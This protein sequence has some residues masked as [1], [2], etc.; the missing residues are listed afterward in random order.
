MLAT[1]LVTLAGLAV[2]ARLLAPG[3]FGLLAFALAYITYVTAIGDLGTGTA[4]IYWPSR[5]GD[6]T[7]V[8]FVISVI[9]GWL[10][11]GGTVLL[12]P[13]IAAFFDNPA[14]APVLIAIAWSVPIQALGS[15]HDALCRKSLRFR[16]WLG[17]ELA[18]AGGKTA[19]SIALAIAG[20]GVWSLVWGHLAGHAFRT[21]LLWMIVPW[22]PTLT[23]PWHL[24]RPMF[25]Y[26]RSIV[27]V[28]VLSV[29][30]HHSDL[31]IVARLLG[32]TALGFYQMAAKIPE[33]AITVLVRAVS[34]VLF[35]AL[36]RAHA[37]GADAVATYL[38]TL[39]GVG[40]VTIPAAV[41]LVMMAEPLVWVV[42][43]PT[44][45]PSVP[46]V[47]ALAVVACLRALGTPGGDLLKAS[48]RPG[49]LVVLAA[50]KAVL[51]LPAL[52][53]AAT[54][55]MLGVALA[56]A[57]VT[58]I[59]ATLD[60]VVACALTRTSGRSV[61]ASIGAGVQAGAAVA[62]GLALVDASLPAAAPPIF[63][64]VALGIGFTAYA[65]AVRL[66]SR[67]T[68]DEVILWGRRL[69]AVK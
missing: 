68:Y 18:L 46:I 9:T 39:R 6:A 19:I 36:S 51:L 34:H 29:I 13:T 61:L 58:A 62:A 22:R 5:N 47:Q 48:G 44:W 55:G 17:P 35:P 52:L 23:M 63:V 21:V 40:L 14:G 7:Q 28:N 20:L 37:E 53:M 15:T 24:V 27:A 60:I 31:L 16:A 64:P 33:M 32:V 69:A 66:V 30:V 50:L 10:W 3:D 65:C 42:F 57:G 12:A 59:T 49:A 43:G 26:G 41:V 8:T 54:A 45:M 11:L 4:L 25:G 67:E 2:L 56:M 1:R 38:T